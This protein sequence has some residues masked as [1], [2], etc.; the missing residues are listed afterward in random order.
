MEMI[1]ISHTGK[2]NGKEAAQVEPVQ[3]GAANPGDTTKKPLIEARNLTKVYQTGAG[4]FTALKDINLQINT[5]EFLAVV[6]KS[7]AGKTTLLNMLSGVSEIS[8]GEVLFHAP[9]NGDGTGQAIS[10]GSL[11]EDEMAV[12]RGRNVG[13]VYQSFELLPQLDLV[14][15]I[16]IPQDFAG[17]FRP[18]ISR[19]RALELLDLVELSEHAYKLPAHVSGGQKQRVAIARALVNDPA[20]ILADE[21]T[22]NLDTVT[23]ETI[24]QLF[25]RLVDGGK[26]ILMVTHDSNLAA[27]AA[28]TVYI[29]D[30]EIASTPL[31]GDGNGNGN[32]AVP[33]KFHDQVERAGSSPWPSQE[34][35]NHGAGE[36]TAYPPQPAII[37]NEVAKTY[38]NAAGSFT[39]LKGVNLQMNY[40]QFI[41]IVGKSGSGKST[42]LNM[43]TGIDH[44]TSGQVIIGGQDLYKMT[45]SKRA[46]WRGRNVG[47]VFQF[48]QLLPTLTLLENTMLPMDYCNV[49]PANQRPQ[50]AMELLKMVG[51]ED[52]A[53]KLPS[54]VSSGQQQSAAIARALATDPPII[55]ADEPTGNLDS[56]S[57]AAIIRLFQQLADQGKTILIVTHDPSITRRTDQTVILS[58]GEIIDNVVARALPLLNHPQM[59]QV[60]RQ[61]EK[62]VYQPGQTI[63]QQGEHVKHFFMVASGEVDVV[64]NKEGCMEMTLACLGAGQFF[65]EVE[66]MNGGKSLASVHAALNGPV[67]VALLDRDEFLR[68]LDEAPAMQAGLVSVAQ[69]RLQEHQA[70]ALE[71]CQ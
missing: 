51:L 18:A 24:F 1:G 10:L 7:G 61:A 23:A 37:L 63:L 26:T 8:S 14:D 56:R 46:L 54:M 35:G 39:A 43:L 52:Q 19:Q 17:G 32:G 71:G 59:L 11:N 33:V 42:L 55:L 28:R 13:I 44:P 40:G 57:A 53:Y 29:S 58:D 38:T 22:G 12:W 45:E 36:P 67:E 65:G 34:A 5:G 15:N 20:L 62:R 66:L 2:Q 69:E 16:M 50:R 31:N 48:F 68:L 3:I 30:G 4:G 60:T 6:G 27:R 41:S 49:F 25:Q 70:H 9:Q 64:L 21:P 47:I